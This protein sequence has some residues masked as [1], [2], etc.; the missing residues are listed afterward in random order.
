MTLKLFFKS[1]YPVDIQM[2]I[3]LVFPIYQQSLETVFPPEKRGD[4]LYWL[5]LL[6]KFEEIEELRVNMIF[7]QIKQDINPGPSRMKVSLLLV[8]TQ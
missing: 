6:L 2:V 7:K 3:K 5:V 8:A 4:D 1:H